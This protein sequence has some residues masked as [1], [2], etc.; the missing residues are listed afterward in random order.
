[1]VTV[2]NAISAAQDIR[3]CRLDRRAG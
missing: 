3:R 1:V 2:I